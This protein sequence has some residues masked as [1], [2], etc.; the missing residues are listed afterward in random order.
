MTISILRLIHDH[1]FQNEY[2]FFPAASG[3]VFLTE[4]FLCASVGGGRCVFLKVGR[5]CM[6]HMLLVLEEEARMYEKV[7]ERYG[8]IYQTP[9]G[10]HR[11]KGVISDLHRHN[12]EQP[13]WS[14]KASFEIV[15]E[16]ASLQD[17]VRKFL[18]RPD[19]PFLSRGKFC[20][21]NCRYF[22]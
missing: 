16:G 20:G 19:D 7:V 11:Q 4:Y 22:R 15:E 6:S 5:S 1:L 21:K 8:P 2:I 9:I 13:Y 3:R 18:E 12:L 17:I 14:Y 10:L